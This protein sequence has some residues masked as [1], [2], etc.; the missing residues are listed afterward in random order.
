M[1]NKQSEM[2]KTFWP[3]GQLKRTVPFIDGVQSDGEVFF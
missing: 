2:N 3:N 1:K